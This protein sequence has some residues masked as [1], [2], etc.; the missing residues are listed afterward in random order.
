M[1]GQNSA[2]M[3]R[4]LGAFSTSSAAFRNGHLRIAW[5]IH[6]STLRIVTDE[7][8]LAKAE[9]FADW[10]NL[11][12]IDQRIACIYPFYFNTNPYRS[13]TK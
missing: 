6:T 5:L 12:V 2:V 3:E 10:H 1:I 9:P 11:R 7:P 4:I 8:F 13:L